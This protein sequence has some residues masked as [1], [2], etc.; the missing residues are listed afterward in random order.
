MPRLLPNTANSTCGHPLSSSLVRSRRLR[1]APTSPS[2]CSPPSP[3][4]GPTGDPA[5]ARDRT[6]HPL[7]PDAGA[8]PD[9][10]VVLGVYLSFVKLSQLSGGG[11]VRLGRLA[12]GYV[13]SLVPIAIAYQ[14]ASSE[15]RSELCGAS[16]PCWRPRSSSPSRASGSSLNQ[17]SR[18]IERPLT[19]RFS[20]LRATAGRAR[21]L[22]SGRATP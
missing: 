9:A 10:A 3:T 11:S 8:L 22:S 16:S 13:Y 19:Y 17:S 5:A 2:S 20:P 18:M 7:N 6:A 14:Y 4:T 12:G 15:I 21:A 1:A